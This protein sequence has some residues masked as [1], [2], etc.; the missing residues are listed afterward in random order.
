LGGSEQFASLCSV[1]NEAQAAIV[2]IF[3][4]GISADDL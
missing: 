2:F 3:A 4:D 1:P